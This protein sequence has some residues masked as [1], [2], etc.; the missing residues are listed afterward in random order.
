MHMLPLSYLTFIAS[1]AVVQ[2]GSKKEDRREIGIP[3]EQC[4]LLASDLELSIP[5][6]RPAFRNLGPLI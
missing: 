2:G 5:G 1:G 4:L 6:N 3:A